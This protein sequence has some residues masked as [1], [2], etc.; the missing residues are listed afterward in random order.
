MY[1]CLLISIT[2]HTHP[3]VYLLARTCKQSTMLLNTYLL[4]RRKTTG[5]Y[6]QSTN[7]SKEIMLAR[8]VV[9]DCSVHISEFVGE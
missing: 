4:G 2:A 8:N 6:P 7:F 1:A 3:Y 9:T 5:D